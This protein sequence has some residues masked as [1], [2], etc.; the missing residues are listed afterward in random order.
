MR[1]RED[2]KSVKSHHTCI[3]IYMTSYIVQLSFLGLQY[4]LPIRFLPSSLTILYRY[5]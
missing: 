4:S 1:T 3:I 5:S 2:R